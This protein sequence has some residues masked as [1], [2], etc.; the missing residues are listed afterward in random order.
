[1]N[2]LSK[3][4]ERLKELMSDHD[5]TPVKL[6]EKILDG[7]NNFIYNKKHP[8]QGVFCWCNQRDSNP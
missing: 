2:N 8:M 6:G 4:P 7:F 1:M 3:L 5:L